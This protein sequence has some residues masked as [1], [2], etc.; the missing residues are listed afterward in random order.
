MTCHSIKA[1]P[2]SP[3]AEDKEVI[4][5]D[6][7]IK[8]VFENAEYYFNDSVN[9]A[10]GAFSPT[11]KGIDW[12]YMINGKKY[13]LAFTSSYKKLVETFTERIEQLTLF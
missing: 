11:D 4:P 1:I 8:R 5:S 13:I 9:N 12:C 6:K 2:C 10:V 3:Y 7:Y